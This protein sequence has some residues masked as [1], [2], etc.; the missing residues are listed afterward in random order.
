[1]MTML[2]WILKNCGVWHVEWINLAQARNL[3][4]VVVGLVMNFR[5]PQKVQNC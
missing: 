4:R 1:M 2:R 5:V 3:W